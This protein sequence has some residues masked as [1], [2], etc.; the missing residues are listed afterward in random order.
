MKLW[1]CSQIKRKGWQ[2]L[3][4]RS[5]GF[6][7]LNIYH[8]PG[9]LNSPIN[10]IIIIGLSRMDIKLSELNWME[11]TL[12]V[13]YFINEQWKIQN[14]KSFCYKVLW[15]FVLKVFHVKSTYST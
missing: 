5:G 3:K 11:D 14:S 1:N 13:L 7:G 12:E 10:A 8:F 6:L 2:R 15:M 9:L 4:T